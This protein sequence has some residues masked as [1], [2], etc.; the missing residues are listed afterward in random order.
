MNTK[1]LVPAARRVADALYGIKLALMILTLIAGSMYALVS[2]FATDNFGGSQVDWAGLVIGTALMLN[3]VWIYALFGF[4][5]YVIRLLAAIVGQSPAYV[6]TV[7][8]GGGSG[9]TDADF[10]QHVATAP[11]EPV[12]GHFQGRG[13]ISP[14]DE[15]ARKIIG[16]GGSK[17]IP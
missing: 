15:E 12:H 16:Q 5:E 2:L 17:L 1:D 10:D 14:S 6:V 8:G 3:A 13:G 9:G 11:I 4:G 7:N